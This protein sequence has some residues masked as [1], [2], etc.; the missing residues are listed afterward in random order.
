M[1]FRARTALALLSLPLLVSFSGAA[2]ARSGATVRSGFTNVQISRDGYKAHSE[3]SVAENPAN[4]N[5]LVAGS[6]F[7]TN[8]ARYRFKIGT[9]SSQ[10]GGRTWRDNGL[11]PGF[12]AYPTTSDITFAFSRSGLVYAVVLACAPLNCPGR[13]SRSGVFLLRS[14]DGGVTWSKPVTVFLDTTGKTFSD[15]PWVTVDASAGPRKGTVYVAWNLDGNTAAQRGGES[16]GRGLSVR[17]RRRISPG[18]LAPGVVVARSTDYGRS[19]AEPVTV[20]P[21]SAT[22]FGLG[23]TPVV[24][25]DGTLNVGFSESR[26]QGP[27]TVSDMVTVTSTDGGVTFSAPRVAAAGITPL[28][29]HLPNSTFRNFSLPTMVASPRD[30]TLLL[31]WAD[32]RNGDAD[33]YAVRSRDRGV[34]WSTPTRLNHDRLQNGKDQFMPI[35]A[36]APNGSFTCAWFDRRRDPGNRLIDVYVAQST[37]GGQTFGKNVRVTLQSWDPA[38]GAPRDGNDSEETFIG[39]YQGLAVDNATVHPVWNDTQNGRSQQIRTAVLPVR[40]FAR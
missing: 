12:G 28:P 15:K 40:V 37:D 16:Q 4:P 27:R 7:F 18:G 14:R 35:C 20:F 22:R 1:P 17:V 13:L 31:A 26:Q 34:T 30:G 36:A 9:Y 32:L 38:I 29:T 33:I 11:L 2:F 6:K 19:F 3:P 25:P 21:F 39:D 23:A 24:G 8:P 10:D 5:N